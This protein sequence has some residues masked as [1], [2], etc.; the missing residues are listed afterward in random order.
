ME[1]ESLRQ[2]EESHLLAPHKSRKQPNSKGRQTKSGDTPGVTKRNRGR[3]RKN[4]P[5]VVGA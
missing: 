2:L 1:G 4:T 3:P 5:K